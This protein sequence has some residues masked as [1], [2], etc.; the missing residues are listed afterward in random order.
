MRE[1]ASGVSNIFCMKSQ[2]EGYK[3]HQLV[4]WADSARFDLIQ[5]ELTTMPS[6]QILCPSI[7]EFF[8][9]HIRIH[10][11]ILPCEG[12][13][14][15]VSSYIQVSL[16]ALC[17]GSPRKVSYKFQYSGILSENLLLLLKK[18]ENIVTS[19]SFITP[20]KVHFVEKYKNRVK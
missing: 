17:T 10:E 7:W 11:Y 6:W 12:L 8:K 1:H 18:D 14:N 13:T 2:I 20:M 15:G 19:S 16:S 9:N 4:S 5:A 3:I